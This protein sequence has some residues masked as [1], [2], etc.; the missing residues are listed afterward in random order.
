MPTAN[1]ADLFVAEQR[2]QRSQ[3]G[4]HAAARGRAA[5]LRQR[6]QLLDGAPRALGVLLRRVLGWMQEMVLRRL[7]SPRDASHS[8]LKISNHIDQ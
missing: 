3:R 2:R 5:V 1:E 7:R 8:P 4:R 6:Q